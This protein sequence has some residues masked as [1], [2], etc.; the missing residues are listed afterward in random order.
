M[1]GR[2]ANHISIA[3]SFCIPHVLPCPISLKMIPSSWSRVLSRASRTTVKRNGTGTT[4][5]ASRRRCFSDVAYDATL[6]LKGIKVLDMT[7]VL[8]GVSLCT[9]MRLAIGYA[10][11]RKAILYSNTGRSRVGYFEP[12]LKSRTDQD[13]SRNY[14]NRASNKRR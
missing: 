5:N 7:R 9:T 13:Q 4:S 10:N 8:A 1:W 2:G 3:A 12:N 11:R 6:P 14:K